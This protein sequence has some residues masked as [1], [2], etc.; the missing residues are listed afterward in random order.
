M[1]EYRLPDGAIP[2]LLT[3]DTAAGLR[4]EATRLSTYLTENDQVTPDRVA[5][6]L[7]RTRIARRQRALIMVRTRAELL[8]ALT[9]VAAAAEHPA[10][11]TGTAS[12]RRIGFVFPGQGSQRPG[13]G[14]LY[15]EL[16]Q[17]YRDEVRA[18]AAVHEER[19]GHA[20][21]LHYLLGEQ[22]RYEDA[23]WE[24]QPALMFH[25]SGLAAMWQ[26]AGVRPAATVGHS[27]GELA[28]GHIAGV[29]TRGDSVYVVTHRSRLVDQLSPR[30]MSM[31]V[32]GMDREA[33]EALLARR[34]G[35]AELAV[36]NSPHILAIAG[37]RD[38][39]VEIIAEATAKGQFAKEIRVSY[40]AHT[41]LVAELRRT[42]QE[43]LFDGMSG[44][45]FTD[46]DIACYGATLG[47][48][49][50]AELEHEEYWYWNLRN[51]VRFDLAIVAAATDGIDTFI[52][53]AEHPTLQLALQE[54]LTLVPRDPTLPPREF[55]VLG[56]SLRTADSLREFTANLAAIAVSDLGYDWQALRVEDA[57]RPPLPN[58]PHTVMNP[59]RL[60]AAAGSTAAESGS[61]AEHVRPLRLAESWMRLER[62]TL[63]PPRDVLVV[64]YTGRCPELAA[65]LCTA[66]YN[67]GGSARLYSDAGVGEADTVVV[68]LPE[69]SDLDVSAAIDEVA[70]FF[71][72]PSWLPDLAGV[73]ECW[74][75][76]VG[77]EA[78]VDSDPAPNL[79][80]G[81]ASSGF[82]C[83]AVEYLG[84][85]FRHVDLAAG[86]ADA[87]VAAA[88]MRALHVKGEP[89]LALRDNGVYA[90]RLDVDTAPHPASG[91]GNPDH[92]V[93]TGGTGALG[94][95]FCEHYVRHGARRITLLSRS[96]ETSAVARRIR[97][98]RA[99]G[100]TEIQVV[101]CDITDPAAVA[102]VTDDPASLIVHAAVNF[103]HADLA[104]ITAEK[105]RE[106]AAAKVFGAD[107]VLRELPRT[108]DCRVV[109]CSSMSATFG[110]RGQ[111]LYAVLN[112][113]LDVLAL[114]LRAEGI[115]AVAVQ[116]GLWRLPG[117]AYSTNADSV[118][119]TGAVT[120]RAADALTT[121]LSEHADRP[122]ADNR[123]VAAADWPAMRDI[124]SVSGFEPLLE[125]VVRHTET[126][127][128]QPIMP[129]TVTTTPEP[130]V[131]A[132]RPPA[133][134]LAEQVRRE[135]GKV[136]G[137]DGPDTLDGSV[138]LVALGL[139]SL[140]ALDFRKRVQSELNRD[141]PVA[142][143]LGGAS[144]D[145]VV[146][147]MATE[148]A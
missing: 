129:A 120:M 42:F 138:P 106:L 113:M 133:V 134:S 147:L 72:D 40:P 121:G 23:V 130:V 78:V 51:R 74:L 41:S 45:R 62:R 47:G 80:H 18:C 65:A 117:E 122:G 46:S 22:G 4:A 83:L 87:S 69:S 13:M 2:V 123:I 38:A 119:A 14:R 76:T 124:V 68:L 54:N 6:M 142:A 137:A 112:R 88:L 66:A 58:F 135:L 16:S 86:H 118:E 44:P 61:D 100:T 99:A 67:H 114:R 136:I 20:Q 89:Q 132:D 146:R 143:I 71:G 125:R 32:L 52:E 12:A 31:A 77:G 101:A 63:V 8:A 98:L 111:L 90:K 28:A 5:D 96:G 29:M 81:A 116:W 126:I 59:Q 55:A 110:G 43:R 3:S 75:V 128:A 33:C 131:V 115:D 109:L 9:A 56:T 79:W 141:L 7:F 93:I 15:Y 82:R 36:I 97:A 95:E 27:Q 91:P 145:D 48:R 49:I 35:W 140:Q 57:V 107:V 139:D 53:V 148:Q 1:S 102:A 26:A 37:D 11:V 25:M 108:P 103:V 94:M 21:P 92:V 50:T 104:E 70:T 39:I 64:D 73:R 144:L 24:V 17:A 10:V 30:G 19:F 84:P 85:D 34:S 60:W 127:A 105:T